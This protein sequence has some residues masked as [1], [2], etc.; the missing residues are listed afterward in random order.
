[1]RKYIKLSLIFFGLLFMLLTTGCK[2]DISEIFKQNYPDA[3]IENIFNSNKGYGLIMVNSPVKKDYVYYTDGENVI[4]VDIPL[5]V[6]EYKDKIV[7]NKEDLNSNLKAAHDFYESSLSKKEKFSVEQK[8][9][10]REA[11]LMVDAIAKKD[12]NSVNSK[13][14]VYFDTPKEKLWR[15]NTV[16]PY[17]DYSLDELNKKLSLVIVDYNKMIDSRDDYYVRMKTLFPKH[18]SELNNSVSGGIRHWM[19]LVYVDYKLSFIMP[20]Y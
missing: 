12:S 19:K 9:L 6:D 15:E 5:L 17:L 7:E 20:S 16:N 4:F 11:S 13:A 3:V 18:F 1:M 10:W 2:K 14:N 8:K